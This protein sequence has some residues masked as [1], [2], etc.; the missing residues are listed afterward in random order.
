MS[1]KF[2]SVNQAGDGV[3]RVTRK[4]A[5]EIAKAA[6]AVKSPDSTYWNRKRGK[7]TK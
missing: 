3:Y 4:Q 1:K 5:G 7:A 6:K 2:Q